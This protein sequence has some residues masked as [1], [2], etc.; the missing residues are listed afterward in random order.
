VAGNLQTI[1]QNAAS[2]VQ[3]M[4][5]P[6]RVTLALAFVATA[7]GVFLV[8]RTASSTPM[9]TLYANLEPVDAAAVTAELDA[10]GVT[11]ELMNGGRVIQVPSAQVNNLRLAMSAQGLPGDSDWAVFDETAGVTS[12]TRQQD[13]AYQRAIEARLA[14]TITA[15]D[16]VSS[17][18]VHLALPERDLFTDD[19]ERASASVL[20]V[21]GNRTVSAMQVQA[22]VNLVSSAVEGLSPDQVSVADETGRVLAAP[23]EGSGALALENDTQFRARQDYEASVEAKLEQLLGMVVGPGRARVSVAAELDFDTVTTV[24]E[25]YRPNEGADGQQIRL[26]ET[27]RDELYQGEDG[28]IE[29]GQLEVEVPAIDGEEG[30]EADGGDGGVTVTDGIEYSL[31]EQDSTYAVDRVVTTSENAKG[32]VTALSVAVLLDEAAVAEDRMGELETLVA[33]A[34][35]LDLDAGDS[36][37]LARMPIDENVAATI[38]ASLESG[39]LAAEAAATTG[40]LDL[41][42]LIRTIGTIIVALVVLVLGL[43]FVSK[44]SKRKVIDSVVLSELDPGTAAQIGAGDQA[45][46]EQGQLESMEEAE[47]RLQSLIANQTD[48]VAD[49][50]R[51]WL[52]EADEVPA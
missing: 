31:N 43:R 52:N 15:I 21:T 40:G 32:A 9:S 30:A 24:T 6:Q 26:S 5:G 27:T 16:G 35:G 38:D 42:G 25:E 34:V 46:G 4:T 22:I 7:L 1:G 28:Q 11:Y 10:Q 14:G 45:D 29:D 33:G 13:V 51:S 12:N 39:D 18:N 20:L 41:I 8:A 17:A 2:S 37:A 23:G 49:V 50:L 48:D 44:G 3:R 19:G 36:L 47:M